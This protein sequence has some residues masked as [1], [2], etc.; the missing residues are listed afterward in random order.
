MKFIKIIG[1]LIFLF[2]VNCAHSQNLF[3]DK[4]GLINRK[5]DRSLIAPSDMNRL[6]KN[7]NS[8]LSAEVKTVVNKT[9]LPASGD[10]HDYYS[11]ATY[12]WP[13]PETKSGLPYVR[14]DGKPNPSRLEIGDHENLKK[15]C[16]DVK[17]LS[18]AYFFTDE[19]QYLRKIE[20]YLNSWF[21][22]D[23]T[24]MNPHLKHAQAIPGVSNGSVVGIIDTR[25]L[26]EML[27]ALYAT[28]VQN[29]LDK[30][31]LNGLNDWFS[32]YL[33]WLKESDFV[34]ENLSKINNNIGTA[35]YM[36]IISFSKFINSQE[37][38]FEGN[39][40]NGV[41]SLLNVQF[42]EDG[43]QNF[44]SNRENSSVYTLSNLV[45]WY[46]IATM[47][48]ENDI[49]LW[50]HTT[51]D[52]K[53]LKEAYSFWHTKASKNNESTLDN[54]ALALVYMS[55]KIYN[56]GLSSKAISSNNFITNLTSPL[57]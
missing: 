11:F 15:L 3:F 7:A 39:V 53:N 57:F 52:G 4:E 49:D 43:T 35:Y 19:S 34:N 24:K 31:V 22:D 33:V 38:E 14:H 20:E 18:L 2:S 56:R 44:E 46:N 8:I 47:L 23:R 29:S 30:N 25:V 10:K 37:L 40:K 21:I 32:K 27:N 26:P 6:I 28:D 54:R 12:W 45:Y 51:S 48:S 9:K 17:I 1:V 16:D 42:G 50:N 55:N 5:Q 36:Q 13:N 41:Y